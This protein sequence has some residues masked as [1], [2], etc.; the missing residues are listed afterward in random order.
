MLLFLQG[1]GGK[2]EKTV[3]QRTVDREG[4]KGLGG[5]TEHRKEMQWKEMILEGVMGGSLPPTAEVI[6]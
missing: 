4:G 3:S 1:V 6:R 5:L 2:K